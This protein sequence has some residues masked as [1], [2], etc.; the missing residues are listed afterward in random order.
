MN[1]SRYANLS[2]IAFIPLLNSFFPLDFM[3]RNLAIQII[4]SLLFLENDVDMV[5]AKHSTTADEPLVGASIR[6]VGV[7]EDLGKVNQLFCDKTGTLTQN[8]LIFKA[9][10]CGALQ[11]TVEGGNS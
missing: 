5:S 10:C 6:T 1:V 11:L 8:E 9:I 7:L 4:Y 2:L 3:L